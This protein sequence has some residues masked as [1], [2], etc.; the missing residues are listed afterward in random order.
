MVFHVSYKES[1]G[2][3]HIFLSIWSMYSVDTLI[4][5]MIMKRLIVTL[6]SPF[7]TSATINLVKMVPLR[8]NQFISNSHKIVSLWQHWSPVK[9]CL[10]IIV[11]WRSCENWKSIVTNFI[12]RRKYVV[13]VIFMMDKYCFGWCRKLS[14]KGWRLHLPL[15]IL[16][17][18]L[19][20]YIVRRTNEAIRSERL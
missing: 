17:L 15:M 8:K 14:Q 18:E 11:S 6:R 20:G 19:I 16:I 9:K 4:V 10:N 1:S 5:I 12:R 13:F 3:F 2:F 7:A